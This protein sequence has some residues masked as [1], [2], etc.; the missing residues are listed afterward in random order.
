MPDISY[1]FVSCVVKRVLLP[2]RQEAAAEHERRGRLPKGDGHTAEMGPEGSERRQNTGGAPDVLAGTRK[3]STQLLQFCTAPTT[4][5]C[6][7]NN[8]KVVT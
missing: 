5:I 2:G 3:V 1:T 7:T 8:L 6:S 4:L